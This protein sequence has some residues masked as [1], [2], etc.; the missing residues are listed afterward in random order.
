MRKNGLRM[1]LF[2][3]LALVLAFGSN[4]LVSAGKP[5]K[6]PTPTP[7]RPSRSSAPGT[8]VTT[9]ATGAWCGI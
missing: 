8:A 2:V 5:T 6:T 7:P 1:V 9:T 4:S 3:L